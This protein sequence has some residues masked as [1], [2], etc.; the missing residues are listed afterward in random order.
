MQFEN[1]SCYIFVSFINT[2]FEDEIFVRW[3]ECHNCFSIISVL[4]TC[5]I[6]IIIIIISIIIINY[7]LLQN[8]KK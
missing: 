3:V 1:S 8:K 5:H 7:Y 4:I 2:N 6:L